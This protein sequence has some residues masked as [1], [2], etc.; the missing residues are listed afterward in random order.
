MNTDE[1][2]I[3][4]GTIVKI[5]GFPC[6]LTEDTKVISSVLSQEAPEDEVTDCREATSNN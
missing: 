2:I 1:V 6:E 3:P 4:K 5:K